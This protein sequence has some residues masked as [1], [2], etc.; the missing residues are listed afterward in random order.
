MRAL[1]LV[2]LAA[3]CETGDPPDFSAKLVAHYPMEDSAGGVVA[4]ISGNK[5]D[6]MCTTCPTVEAGMAGMAFRFDGG[7][8]QIDVPANAA[9]NTVVRGF[10]A[11]AWIKLDMAPPQLPGCAMVKGSMWSICVNP[12]MQPAFGSFAAAATLTVGT[13]HHIAISYDGKSRRIVLDGV[14]AG[15][16]AASIPSE[17][18]QLVLGAELIGM[19]DD[20]R[21][22]EGVLTDDEIA[23]LRTP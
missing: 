17:M 15:V 13:W 6:G 21:I 9:F 1:L 3:G 5:R 8:Q 19:A 4:D 14:E 2:I 7:D 20:A 16:T 11:A 22:Y 23:E 10:S 18:G 12:D